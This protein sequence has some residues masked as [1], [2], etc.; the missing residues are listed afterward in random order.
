MSKIPQETIP[1][2]PIR[3]EIDEG[4][5]NA[6]LVMGHGAEASTQAFQ[7]GS[8]QTHSSVIKEDKGQSDNTSEEPPYSIFTNNEKWIVVSI[9]S[10]G[11]LFRCVVVLIPSANGM[12]SNTG[13]GVLK[14]AHS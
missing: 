5:G 2:I 14:S 9:A 7:P 8:D 1:A 12:S 4:L 13:P 10:L 6:Q 3:E 11:G